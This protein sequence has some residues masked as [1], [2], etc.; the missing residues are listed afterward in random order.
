MKPS[1]DLFLA[2]LEYKAQC[3]R[4]GVYPPY[5]YATFVRIRTQ[6]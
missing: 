3:E 5:S 6:F 4:N 2:Y 1:Q